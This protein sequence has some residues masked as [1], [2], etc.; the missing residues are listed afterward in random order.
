MIGIAMRHPEIRLVKV[1]IHVN[2]QAFKGTMEIK[3]TKNLSI[4]M[5]FCIIFLSCVSVCFAFLFI[6]IVVCPFTFL[7]SL[8]C[9]PRFKNI[10]IYPFIVCRF[11]TSSVMCLFI[12]CGCTAV[13]VDM[14]DHCTV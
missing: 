10:F 12:Q 7:F 5:S 2:I 9:L 1:L 11:Q 8:R 14:N 4:Y 13:A 3:L 6:D